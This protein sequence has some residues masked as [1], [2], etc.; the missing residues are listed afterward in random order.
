MK[1]RR[2]SYRRLRTRRRPGVVLIVVIVTASISL[3]LFGIWAK[4]MV[5][6]HHRFANHRYRMQ[7]SRLAEAGVRRAIA[8]KTADAAFQQ[9]TWS[10]PA[11]AFG[12]A[13]VGRVQLSA[14]PS[15]GDTSVRYEATAQFPADSVRRAKV[16]KSIELPNPPSG[17]EQ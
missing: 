11:D 4:N 10:V 17:T 1:L 9:E 8:R 15:A 6:E 14:R 16:T 12:G 3:M 7:A 13:N 2:P 5:K